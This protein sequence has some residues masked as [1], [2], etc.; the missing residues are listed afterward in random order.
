MTEEK[1][2]LGVPEIEKA[3]V[4][5]FIDFSKASIKEIVDWLFGDVKLG[6]TDILRGY[7]AAS[8]PC[9]KCNKE[10]KNQP[11]GA[12]R[13]AYCFLNISKELPVRRKRGIKFFC[14]QH[15]EEI[16]AEIKSR[17]VEIITEEQYEEL[18]KKLNVF[19]VQPDETQEPET[20]EGVTDTTEG[21]D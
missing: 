12:A 20:T 18:Q 16:D 11:E 10:G 3:E 8:I 15:A 5:D 2:D 4:G 21:V 9:K 1:K 7:V 17:G 13:L 14:L 19:V 6:P